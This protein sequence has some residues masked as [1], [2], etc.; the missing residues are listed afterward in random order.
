ML[1]LWIFR[2]MVGHVAINPCL[3]DEVIAH[4]G[5]LGEID[6]ILSPLPKG[7]I[8]KALR[9]INVDRRARV[10]ASNS[11]EMPP[12]GWSVKGNADAPPPTLHSFASFDPTTHDDTCHYVFVRKQRVHIPKGYPKGAQGRLVRDQMFID[13]LTKDLKQNMYQACAANANSH[14]K[15][16]S[17][18]SSLI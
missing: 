1:G 7:F 8:S 13:D 11:E 4:Q 10:L 9:I 16:K 6:V 12:D 5:S 3:C 17:T 2:R 15:P 18:D 14:V